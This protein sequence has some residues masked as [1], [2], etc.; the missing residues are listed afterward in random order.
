MLNQWNPGSVF[1][2]PADAI[3]ADWD[4]PAI[5]FS[6]VHPADSVSQAGPR[7]TTLCHDLDVEDYRRDHGVRIS[8]RKSE[9][10]RNRHRSAQH[11]RRYHEMQQRRAP[12]ADSPSPPPSVT[13]R[14]TSD[15]GP[16]PTPARLRPP[17]RPPG[18]GG[19]PRD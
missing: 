10:R 8:S 4:D 3:T 18:R 2:T 6:D 13:G 15:P 16:P 12:T 19:H 14:A 5:E 17:L 7:P 1:Q 11:D 9:M